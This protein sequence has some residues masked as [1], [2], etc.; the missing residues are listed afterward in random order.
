MRM[1][2]RT[3]KYW[4]NGPGGGPELFPGS[5]VQE[6]PQA[7]RLELSRCEPLERTWRRSLA[8]DIGIGPLSAQNVT[9]L[10]AA[11]SVSAMTKA[12]MDVQA[13]APAGLVVPDGQV[14]H[15]TAP[16]TEC[17][18]PAGQALWELLPGLATKLPGEACVH[19]TAPATELKE[20]AGQALWELLPGLATKLPGEAC[21]HDTAPATEL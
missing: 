1:D 20:P 8:R 15:D 6:P 10:P 17:R 9:L 16:A 21:V 3:A 4:G 14:V 18:R 12:A 2:T 19:D 11:S 13:L 5:L 7:G